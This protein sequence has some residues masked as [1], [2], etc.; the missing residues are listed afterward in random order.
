MAFMKRDLF[1]ASLAG[2]SR[3]SDGAGKNQPWGGRLLG[4]ALFLSCL[5]L[6]S[7]VTT[8]SDE[9]PRGGFDPDPPSN[10]IVGMWTST[11]YFAGT[12]IIS[13]L[14]FNADGT[15]LSRATNAGDQSFPFTW[16]Y[17][18]GGWWTMSQNGTYRFRMTPEP[19]A[20]GS[21]FLFQDYGSF[22]TKYVRVK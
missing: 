20:G 16:T 7:C 15:G 6:T 12:K 3:P 10:A 18:G 5:F 11:R 14:L 21:R 4:I 1:F 8:T 19:A 22:V 2:S 13:H 17:D 9:R